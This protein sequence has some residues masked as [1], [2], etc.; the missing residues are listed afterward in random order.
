[1]KRLTIIMLV[2]L[3]GMA[4]NSQAASKVKYRAFTPSGAGKS[5][6]AKSGDKQYKYF[7]VDKGTSFGFDVT[8]PATVKIRTRA[9]FKPNI[10]SLDYEIQI[11]EAERLISG[12]KVK[13]SPATILI[14]SSGGD[15]A[16]KVTGLGG[17]DVR[18]YAESVRQMF[19][20]P[21]RHGSCFDPPHGLP[22]RQPPKRN[23]EVS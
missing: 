3:L 23:L 12:R 13:A 19:T 9:A 14:D 16:V 4:A 21:R 15:I 20:P 10:K 22:S 7:V 2:L 6:F 1:M 5:A 8:G 17:T 11:W 18:G